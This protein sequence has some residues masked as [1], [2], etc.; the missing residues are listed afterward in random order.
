MLFHGGARE[1]H[2]LALE[3]NHAN[4]ACIFNV[5]H[6]HL[7]QIGNCGARMA[8]GEAESGKIA[9]EELSLL[10]RRIEFELKAGV[11]GEP[12]RQTPLK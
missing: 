3:L 9:G 12:S 10:D 1:R 11:L 6:S 4:R 2:G 8:K 5:L 7:G